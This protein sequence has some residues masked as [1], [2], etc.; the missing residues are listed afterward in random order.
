MQTQPATH[1]THPQVDWVCGRPAVRVQGL[2]NV[3]LGQKVILNVTSDTDDEIHGHIGGSRLRGL[4]SGW[5]AGQGVAQPE[6]AAA[7]K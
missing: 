3:R 1:R 7:S 2:I 6:S 5:Q 4:V